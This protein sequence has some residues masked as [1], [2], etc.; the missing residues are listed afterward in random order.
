MPEYAPPPEEA[1]LSVSVQLEMTEDE[2][3]QNTPPP[4]L[5]PDTD[6][7]ITVNPESAEVPAKYTQ[8][9]APRPS[10]VVNCGPLTLC[11]V[12]NGWI[13]SRLVVPKT[14][15]HPVA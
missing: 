10:I 5:Y 13:T 8:R 4:K 12:R 3:S 6:P 2:D 15:R 9:T 7:F 11:K 1:E 14:A